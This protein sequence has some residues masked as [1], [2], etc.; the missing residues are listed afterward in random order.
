[1]VHGVSRCSWHVGVPGGLSGHPLR[2]RERGRKEDSALFPASLV[3]APVAAPVQILTRPF[4]AMIVFS[5][6]LDLRPEGINLEC[7]CNR[8]FF[9]LGE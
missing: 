9:A 6:E 5:G 4:P 3:N 7:P 2:L 8:P 1:M